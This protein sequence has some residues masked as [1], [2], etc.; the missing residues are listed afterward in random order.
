MKPKILLITLCF[1]ACK[2]KDPYE[3]L[4]PD[5]KKV[6]LSERLGSIDTN[7]P[8][9]AE[10]ISEL[11][12]IINLRN[13]RKLLNPERL[14]AFKKQ[15]WFPTLK[16]SANGIL[17]DADTSNLRLLTEK[18]A[19]VY[20]KNVLKEKPG[21]P[22]APLSSFEKS[23]VGVWTTQPVPGPNMDKSFVFYANRLVVERPNQN[24][25]KTRAFFR[26]GSWQ[27]KDSQLYISYFSL[28]TRIGGKLVTEDH[29]P[30]PGGELVGGTI[31][32]MSIKPTEDIVL[33]LSEMTDFPEFR[34]KQMNFDR[35]MYCLCQGDPIEYDR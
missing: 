7:Q 28:A 10:H 3:M 6:L 22:S 18:A 13:G 34:T 30:C 16:P 24:D 25:C 23:I 4:T 9:A 14:P 33:Q 31:S 5:A 11:I 21:I 19:I 2:E 29:G 20:L 27:I 15:P 17:N 35:E 8:Q 32:I 1:L 26:L 12:D